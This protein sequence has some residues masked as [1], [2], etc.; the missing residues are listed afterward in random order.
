MKVSQR[1]ATSKA[2]RHLLKLVSWKFQF[3]KA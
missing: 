2:E 3:V 1:N